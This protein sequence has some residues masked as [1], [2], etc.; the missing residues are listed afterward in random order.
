MRAVVLSC[1]V[2][3][4]LAA[5][6]AIAANR[7]RGGDALAADSI[8]GAQWSGSTRPEPRGLSAVVLKAQVQLSRAGFSSGVIDAR[9]G[10]NYRKAL[11]AFQQARGLPTSGRLDGATWQELAA[12]SA[13]DI[14]SET[15]ITEK[16]VRGP[17]LKSIPKDFER[18]ADLES[19]AYRSSREL[20]AETFHMSEDLIS[21]LNKGVDFGRAQ[22]RILVANVARAGA[23]E[24]TGSTDRPKH[25]G[26]N[27]PGQSTKNARKGDVRV[28]VNKSERS[29]SVYSDEGRLIAYYPV[30]VGSSEKPAPSGAFEVSA[31]AENPTYRYNPAYGF[32]GQKATRPVVVP[33]GPN[34]PVGVVW[35]A[36]SAE[37]YGI[38]GTP[39]PEKIGKSESHGCIRLTNW[40]ALA[41]AK[42]VKKGTPVEF[43]E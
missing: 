38:H 8:N 25:A 15:T 40:D 1:F 24:T 35:I 39:E 31:V 3:L 18:M 16:D 4:T 21:A 22:T 37:S 2:V 12:V 30:S 13:D 41:L 6:P 26:K 32:K 9:V 28:L 20:L 5:G 34:N 17:F 11:K 27:G 29:L 23:I 42:L 10:A 7:S 14:V 19:L 43:V 33:P 36:L